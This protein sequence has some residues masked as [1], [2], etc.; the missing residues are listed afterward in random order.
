MPKFDV[1]V[2]NPPYKGELHLEFL[3]IAIDISEQIVVFIQPATWVLNEKIIDR[4]K[5]ETAL[6]EKISKYAFNL[7]LYNSLTHF[8]EIK[9]KTFIGVSYINKEIKSYIMVENKI[10]GEIF[11]YDDINQISKYGN[12]DTYLSLKKKIIDMSLKDNL[13]NHHNKLHDG[14]FFIPFPSLTG[15]VNIDKLFGNDFYI[16]ITK[17]TIIENRENATTK[18]GYIF[19]SNEEAE[20]FLNY[21]K[22]DFARFALSISKITISLWTGELASV[23]WLDFTQ[24]WDDKKLYNY[25]QL[26]EDEIKFIE[27]NIPEYYD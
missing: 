13:K 14:N 6:K 12:S 26:T 7:V 22:T 17:N 18:N 1:V 23:P 5:L 16:F 11:E 10:N 3:D 20:N 25:F 8:P 15:S 4:P 2:G 9:I 27:K 24:N 19:K 21:L